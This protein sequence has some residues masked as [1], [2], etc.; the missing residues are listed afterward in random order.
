MR[1]VQVVPP[2]PGARL[3]TPPADGSVPED[4]RRPHHPGESRGSGSAATLDYRRLR[5]RRARVPLGL[6]RSTEVLVRDRQQVPRRAHRLRRLLAGRDADGLRLPQGGARRAL[7]A[8]EPH[9]FQLPGPGDMRYRWVEA[10]M[11]ALDV[12]EMTEL[13]ST[14]GGCASRSRSPLA[15]TAKLADVDFDLPPDLVAY[16]AELDEFIER[17]INQSTKRCDKG[18]RRSNRNAHA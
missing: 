10:R 15:T 12:D 2:W 6:E 9:K 16:L 8:A 3:P 1:R 17:E 18:S 14:P 11:D 7:V 4:A 13:V 5:R